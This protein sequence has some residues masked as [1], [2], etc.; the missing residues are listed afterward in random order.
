MHIVDQ[1]GNILF[2]SEN[3][4]KIFGKGAIG[5]KCWD[6]YRDDKIQCNDCPLNKG[7]KIGE[8]DIYESSGALGG[9]VFE[10]SHTGMIFNGKPAMLEIFKDITEKKQMV[11]D[12]VQG[13]RN[14]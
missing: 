2:Q 13:Q 14:C 10:I 7:I 4:E 5:S 6:L 9:K 11:K 12:L 3:F 8:T 1:S